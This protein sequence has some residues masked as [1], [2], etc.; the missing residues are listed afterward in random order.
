MI[1]ASLYLIT[2]ITLDCHVVTDDVIR[3]RDLA[4]AEPAFLPLPGD[5]VVGD[6]PLPGAKRILNPSHLARVANRYGITAADLSEVCFERDMRQLEERDLLDAFHRALSIPGTKV[7]LVEFSRFP[8]PVGDLIFP[9][10]GLALG[11]S[12]AP[13]LWK[14]YVS[15][16]GGKQFPIWA[17]VKL[18]STLNRVIATDNLVTSKPVRADQ[19]RM[20]A[21][22]GVPDALAPAQSLDQVVGKTLL[23]PVHRGATI[24][25]DDV[26]N[27]ISVRRGDQVDVDFLSPS[28]HLRFDATAEMD[29]RVGDRIRLRNLQSRNSFVAEVCGKDQARVVA[30]DET[31]AE[32]RNHMDAHLCAD[33]GLRGPSGEKEGRCK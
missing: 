20:E 7:E 13:L 6:S 18:H 32:R 22:D 33:G 3:V 1:I 31:N 27:A 30:S 26:A 24:S 8:A 25:L 15:Y 14:G 11:P 2:A 10:S 9:R 21:L 16:G 4:A 23:R 5:L 17:R 29:G 12:S 19:V 28:L